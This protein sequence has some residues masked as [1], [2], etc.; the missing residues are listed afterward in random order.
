MKIYSAQRF[1]TGYFLLLNPTLNA[2]NLYRQP[3]EEESVQYSHKGGSSDKVNLD[4]KMVFDGRKKKTQLDRTKNVGWLLTKTSI[5]TTLR[6]YTCLTA[7]RCY[8]L[9]DHTVLNHIM[10]FNCFWLHR[11]QYKRAVATHDLKV[12]NIT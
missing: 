4:N 5:H 1:R 6:C 11:N 8:H 10:S 9:F 2:Y 12:R 7:F 3:F